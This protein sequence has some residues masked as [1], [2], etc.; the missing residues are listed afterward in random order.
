MNTTLT[1]T[2]V[3]APAAANAAQLAAEAARDARILGSDEETCQRIYASVYAD[4]MR[5]SA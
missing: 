5:E 3:P 2:T 1:R 4:A